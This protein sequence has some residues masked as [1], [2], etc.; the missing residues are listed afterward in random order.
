M[1]TGEHAR[2]RDVQGLRAVAV[3]AVIGDHV[4]QWP[5]AGF[6]GVDVFFVISGYLITGLLLREHDRSGRISFLG[7]YRRRFKRIVPAAVLVIAATI[8]AAA[9]L[10]PGARLRSTTIDAAWALL[11]AG[12]WRFARQGTD[13]FQEGQVP[14]PLRHYWSLGVEEQ[15][16][17]VW[18]WLMLALLAFAIGRLGWTRNRGHRLAGLVIAFGSLVSFAYAVKVSR[19]SPNWAYFTSF[20]RIWELGAGAVVAVFAGRFVLRPGLARWLAWLGLAGVL[21]SLFVVDPGPSFPAPW[22]ALP[23]L[24][25]ALLLATGGALPDRDLWPLTNRVSQYLGDTSYSLYLWHFPVAILLLALMDGETVRYQLV[26]LV[27]IAA[28]AFLS[29]HLVEDPLR[30]ATWWEAWRPLPALAPL[31][32]RLVLLIAAVTVVSMGF[33]AVLA[34]KVSPG[35]NGDAPDGVTAALA[36]SA[37]G[38]CL[39]AAAKTA[40]CKG[41]SHGSMLHPL[42]RYVGVDLGGAFA[43]AC[44]MNAGEA[45]KSCRIG[46]P[47]GLRVALVGDSHA[48]SLL[49]ALRLK[50]AAAGWSVDTFTGVGCRISTISYANC[51]AQADITKRLL[52]GLRYDVMITTA[53]RGKS[54]DARAEAAAS[55]AAW[56]PV[57]ARGTRIVVVADNPEVAQETLLCVQRRGFDASDS[58]STP[59]TRATALPDPMVLAAAIAKVPVVDLVSYFCDDRICPAVIGNVLVYRDA[60]GHVTASYMRTL[61]PYLVKAIKDALA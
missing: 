51:P 37:D 34:S 29:F 47:S 17:L 7:F 26:A 4:L 21:V 54:L 12:N 49:P 44:W 16:Y 40:A 50:A 10:T 30:R 38:H 23:V 43:P 56:R 35:A 58:C 46:R 3:L 55:A 2:R 45:I 6:V 48:A 41:F 9:A 39:G 18:P 11:F 36:V 42:P 20:A 59:R 19:D 22:G 24:S 1:P 27:V 5:R 57:L 33:T 8:A 28:A 15:F 13:Y 61:A 14:S 31:H 60:A 25:A 52:T 53:S 32:R